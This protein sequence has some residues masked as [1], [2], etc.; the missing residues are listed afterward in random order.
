MVSS[1]VCSPRITSTSGILSTGE[2]KCRPMNW[3]GRSE[4]FARPVIGSVEVFASEDEPRLELFL[5][6]QLIER[7]LTIATAES[8]TGGL[9]SRLLTDVPGISAVFREGWV[10]YTTTPTPDAPKGEYGAHFWLNAGN[11]DNLAEFADDDNY[12]FVHGSIDDAALVRAAT[13]AVGVDRLEGHAAWGGA[14]LG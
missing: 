6:R 8:C 5:G 12:R 1:L 14:G 13:L 4:A 7:G 2:K 9:V 11:P 10:T 3:S